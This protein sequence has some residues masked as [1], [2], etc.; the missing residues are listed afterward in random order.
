MLVQHDARV[1]YSLA[2]ITVPTLVVAGTEGGFADASR[3]LAAKIPGARLVLVDGAGHEPHRSH[4]ERFETQLAAFL[5][6]LRDLRE[7]RA[8]PL[9]HR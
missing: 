6:D 8:L 5:R 2:S 3:Y 4:P 9:H 1:I 7:R